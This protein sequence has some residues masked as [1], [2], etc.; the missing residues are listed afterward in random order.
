MSKNVY[1]YQIGDSI[2][3]NI[4]NKCTNKCVFCIRQAKE[5]IAG[6]DLW[7]DKEPD[8]NEL[9]LAVGDVS[10]YREVVFCGYGEPLI[11]AD[12]VIETSRVL[13]KLGA[14]VRIDTNGQADLIHGRDI[15]SELAGSVDAVSI[16]LNAPDA[17]QYVSL[18]QPQMGEEAYG[19]MLKFA[20][21][22]KKHIPKVTLSVV[23]LPG[24]DIKKCREIAVNLGA[25][26]II[27][28]YLDVFT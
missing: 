2:Y 25:E 1:A 8:L 26:F 19:A 3:L 10:Q 27:R 11:R 22:C 14:S 7:L 4:T 12:L 23:R 24:V 17:L 28:E 15:A 18:C 9:L 6:Y 21:S 16:S 13:K 20:A 5:G